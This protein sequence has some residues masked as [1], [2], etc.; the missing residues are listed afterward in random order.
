SISI[1]EISRGAF[2]NGVLGYWI[3][4]AFARRGFMREAIG[5]CVRR[6]F[7]D[8][9]LHR[10]EANIMPRNTASRGLIERCGFRL[11]GYSPR[12]LQIGGRWEDHERWALT[13]EESQ[14]RGEIARDAL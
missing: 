8:L 13:E 9:G 12:Y 14:E 5:L 7:V 2:Q 3:G 10:L 6:A 4:E 1:N 11:E